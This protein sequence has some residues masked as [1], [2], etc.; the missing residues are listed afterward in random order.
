M[1]QQDLQQ[2]FAQLQQQ[3]LVTQQE[4]VRL[5]QRSDKDARPHLCSEVLG[6]LPTHLQLKPME[7]AE[8]KGLLRPYAKFV[9]LPSVIKDA[10]GLGA[11]ALGNSADKKWIVSHVPGFQSDTLDII[12]I[13]A[14]TWHSAVTEQRDPAATLGLYEQAIK[15]ILLIGAD[16]AQR[17]AR[18]QLRQTFEA[19]GAKGAYA[20]LDLG[21]DSQDLDEKDSNLFQPAHVHALQELK[22]YNTAIDASKPKTKPTQRNNGLRTFGN[23]GRGRGGGFGGRG[24]F[25]GRGYGSRGGSRGSFGSNRGSGNGSNSDHRMESN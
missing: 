17:L 12:R 25:G 4:L 14:G 1:D 13:A 9:E 15:D 22:K 10:N 19:N 16:N 6:A 11:R 5:A 21:P 24:N 7:D 8:R 3:L 20:L 23:R 18:T 2:Q